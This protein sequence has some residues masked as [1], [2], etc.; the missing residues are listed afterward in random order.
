MNTTRST[1][2]LLVALS[3][4]GAADLSAQR[5]TTDGGGSGGRS[6]PSSGGGSSGSSAPSRD[7]DVSSSSGPTVSRAGSGTSAS[8]SGST[9]QGTSGTG[10]GTTG[11]IG[12]I[13]KNAQAARARS[14]AATGSGVFI[15][16]CWNCNYWGWYGDQW[17]W[18]D[19]G[20]W[21][22]AYY[23]PPDYYPGDGY[24]GGGSAGSD[25]GYQ[26]Y[27]YAG[28]DSTSETFAQRH[29]SA[30][31]T[32]GALTLMH[33]SDV[34]ST[35]TAGQIGLEGAIGLL[36]GELEFA[37][38]AEPLVG[39]TDRLQTLRLGLAA[40]PRIS[41]NAYLI[42]GV[43]A[44]GVFLNDGS[45]AWGPEGELGIQAFPL[46]PFGFNVTERLAG[47][48]WNGND[49]FLFQELNT[50][51]SVFINR[52]ELQAGWHWMKV[53]DAPAFGG[54]IVGMRVWF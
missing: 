34:G 32:Y 42:A 27:P 40:Q 36:R 50:T 11:K 5:R 43:A 46:R 25:Q 14:G 26:P 16:A 1:L 18:Y 53:G 44:R 22:P 51:G 54:P 8:H 6:A 49:Y 52:F 3:F 31:R 39:G 28:A 41:N 35:T 29:A 20:W 15:G 47:L 21:Y 30:R 4:V 17:G 13:K 2:A 37:N 9:A 19:G 38:Y 7:R 48:S 10:T 24:A 45:R 23:P 33:F 12:I